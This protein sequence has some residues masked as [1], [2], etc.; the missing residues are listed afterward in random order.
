MCFVL[1]LITYKD[2]NFLSIDNVFQPDYNGIFSSI[3]HIELSVF[4]MFLCILVHRS[5]LFSK[6]LSQ[7]TKNTLTAR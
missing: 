3:S 4:K 7:E 1:F 2:T 5:F 6:W